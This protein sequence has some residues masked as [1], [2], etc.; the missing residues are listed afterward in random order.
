[1]KWRILFLGA[2]VVFGCLSAAGAQGLKKHTK[3]KVTFSFGTFTTEEVTKIQDNV[4][5]TDSNS[6]FKGK[7]ITGKLAG[8][9]L[10]S[11]KRAEIVNL[12]EGKV[13]HLD[14]KKKKCQVQP[15]VNL[16]DTLEQAQASL[17]ELRES[18]KE[19][20]AESRTSDE[21]E[22]LEA[23]FRVEDTGETA[24]KFDFDCRKFW[25]NAYAKWRHKE[26]GQTGTDSLSVISWMTADN[27]DLQKA[28]E[29]EMD[30]A[31]AYLAKLGMKKAVMGMK[32]TLLGGQWLQILQQVNAGAVQAEGYP[33][34]AEELEKL[35]G[36]VPV[37]V[38]GAYFVLRKEPP[39]QQTAEGE[40]SDE[41]QDI[42]S[43]AA[44]KLGGFA[45]SLFGGKKKKKKEGPQRVLA[46]YT[47]TREVAL[48]NIDPGDF[49]SPYKCKEK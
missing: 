27:D 9:F 18:W 38:D 28:R 34:M 7:G 43:Q 40:E 32:E 15:I 20:S 11:G 2:A 31:M 17:D 16:A 10:K 23:D 41:P 8:A 24:R 37:V 21:V 48:T 1:M 33:N 47:E 5:R 45:K 39:K 44:K 25:I 6:K 30:F 29:I 3:S 35:K 22:I 19:A 42:E 49:V 12:E 46:F 36:H 14:L 26:T 4:K 13:Y